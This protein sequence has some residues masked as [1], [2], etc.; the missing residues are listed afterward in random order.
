MEKKGL[1]LFA[2]SR[3]MVLPE[4]FFQEVMVQIS[5][6]L[7]F[8]GA[9]VGFIQLFIHNISAGSVNIAF[10]GTVALLVLGIFRAR[11]ATSRTEERESRIQIALTVG[12]ILGL[13]CFGRLSGAIFTVA[14]WFLGSLFFQASQLNWISWTMAELWMPVLGSRG[15]TIGLGVLMLVA[16]QLP[17]GILLQAGLWDMTQSVLWFTTVSAALL[18]IDH[19]MRQYFREQKVEAPRAPATVTPFPGKPVVH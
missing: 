1:F 2:H 8:G 4:K 15:R 13:T 7:V 16:L 6:V 11:R 17:M 10:V 14:C 5:L 3:R 12:I 18:G 19:T 9:G